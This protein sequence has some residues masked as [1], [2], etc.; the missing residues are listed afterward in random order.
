[1]G[2]AAGC[3]NASRLVG[4]LRVLHLLALPP[5]VAR[6]AVSHYG[7]LRRRANATIHFATAMRT[8][9]R[10][11]STSPGATPRAAATGCTAAQ[12][13]AGEPEPPSCRTT[14]VG[15][16]RCVATNGALCGTAC[17]AV[18]TAPPGVARLIGGGIRVPFIFACAHPLYLP[19]SAAPRRQHSPRHTS[20][21]LSHFDAQD[22]SNAR[23]CH[24][25]GMLQ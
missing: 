17:C 20:L 25:C 1:M 24:F 10:R 19:N 5:P 2:S 3:C 4:C 7:M 6:H 8:R 14:R 22:L 9:L 12:H 15:P 18:A 21:P 16:A 13:Y 23:L 11:A